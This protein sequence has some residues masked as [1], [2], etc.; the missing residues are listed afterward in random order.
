MSDADAKVVILRPE[1]TSAAVQGMPQ[2]FGISG[3]TAGAKGLSMNLTAFPPGG[4]SKA[5]FHRDYETA[6]YGISGQIALYHGHALEQRSLIEPGTFCFIPAFLP[7]VA[8]NLSDTEPATALSARNDP[9]EQENVVLTPELDGKVD[10]D[11][12]ALKQQL[13]KAGG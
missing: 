12:A 7:H 5:H 2:F 10:A 11:A 3:Q 6:I 1:I 13:A 9:A 4:K 8:F